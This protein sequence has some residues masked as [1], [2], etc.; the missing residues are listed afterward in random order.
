MSGDSTNEWYRYLFSGSRGWSTLK[1][2]PPLLTFPV[3]VAP[4]VEL[5]FTA[6]SR[7]NV[8]PTA[9]PIAVIRLAVGPVAWSFAAVPELVVPDRPM[10]VG[11]LVV[12]LVTDRSGTKLTPKVPPKGAVLAFVLL[13]RLMPL[14]GARR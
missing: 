1:P 3:K 2:P 6:L 8:L 11:L 14:P 9:A 7:V 12:R 5:M 10:P 4:P 13:L